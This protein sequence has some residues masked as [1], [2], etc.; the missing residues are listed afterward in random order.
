MDKESFVNCVQS[1]NA[2]P[3]TIVTV[4]GISIP[5]YELDS[6]SLIKDYKFAPMSEEIVFVDGKL[7]T[8]CESAS[9]KYIFGNL[10]NAKWCYYTDLNWDD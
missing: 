1:E 2:L 10:T 7:Y 4:S 5:L 9:D 3:F 6:A 8:M